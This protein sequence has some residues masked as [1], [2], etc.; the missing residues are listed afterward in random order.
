MRNQEILEK[1]VHR[2]RKALTDRHGFWEGEKACHELGLKGYLA[3][4][5]LEE[6]V[7][8]PIDEEVHGSIEVEVL[9]PIDELQM[10]PS[11]RESDLKHFVAEHVITSV[12]AELRAYRTM[13]GTVRTEAEA[14][15]DLR[16]WLKMR[17]IELRKK[18]KA[19]ISEQ[20][21]L[22]NRVATIADSLEGHIRVLQHEN[23]QR[24]RYPVATGG[25]EFA[26]SG[27][28]KIGEPVQEQQLDSRFQIRLAVIFA[29]F[30]RGESS[31][32]SDRVSLK[33]IA[34]L[35]VLFIVCSDLGVLGKDNAVR[36]NHNSSKVSVRNVYE[37]LTRAKI[38]TMLEA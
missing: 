25:L 6:K 20:P 5:R 13:I 38:Q 7:F 35:I 9:V 14:R 31:K 19:L 34:R 17:A 12:C 4:V 32:R 15:K 10:T 23:E 27:V 37:N 1:F 11:V 33:T 30:L 3:R 22:G 21:R 8:L 16:E 36:L 28:R 2:W 24:W 26:R 18:S 29:T